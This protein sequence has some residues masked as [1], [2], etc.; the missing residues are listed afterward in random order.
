M[1][2]I[3]RSSLCFTFYITSC[4]KSQKEAGR[5]NAVETPQSLPNLGFGYVKEWFS[6][7]NNEM[8]IY[9]GKRW[10]DSNDTYLSPQYLRN[11]SWK[12]TSIDLRICQCWISEREFAKTSA[13]VALIYISQPS[14][15]VFQELNLIFK[16][17]EFNQF[18]HYFKFNTEGTQIIVFSLFKVPSQFHHSPPLPLPSHSNS[19]F[20]GLWCCFLLPPVQ[21]EGWW[22]GTHHTITMQIGTEHAAPP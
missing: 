11:N 14:V 2:V 3:I 5:K 4:A 10:E 20:S 21:L 7:M 22:P 13:E 12:S 18:L 16:D 17:L 1:Q 15:L 6:G 19:S 9:C 8:G